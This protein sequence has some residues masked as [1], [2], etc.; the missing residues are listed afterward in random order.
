[1]SRVSEELEEMRSEVKKEAVRAFIV[2][3]IK[4]LLGRGWAIEQIAEVID[5]DEQ[6]VLSVQNELLQTGKSEVE[7][8]ANYE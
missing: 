1:M 3:Q 5:C 7:Q 8:G 6:F 4:R 2:K